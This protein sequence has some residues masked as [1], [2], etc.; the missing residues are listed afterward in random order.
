MKGF[1]LERATEGQKAYRVAGVLLGVA[2]AIW[3]KVPRKPSHTPKNSD[4]HRCNDE[5]GCAL[6]FRTRERC[7]FARG[8]KNESF[9]FTTTVIGTLD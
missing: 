5:L 9:A 3:L 6:R 4:C 7:A 1:S 8:P 2:F